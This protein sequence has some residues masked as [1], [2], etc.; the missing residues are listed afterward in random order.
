MVTYG[1]TL[2]GG[3]PIGVLCGKA[4]LMKRFDLNRPTDICFARG[5]FN[6]HPY[7]MGTMHEFLRNLNLKKIKDI[8]KNLD[9]KWNQRATYLNQRFLEERLPLRVSNFSSIWTVEYTKPSRYNWMYQYYLRA[10][11]I[12]L[13]WVG[14]GRMIFSLN[15]TDDDFQEV[16]SRM[17]AAG[18]KMKKDHWWWARCTAT[19][20]S[21]KREILKELISNFLRTKL[22]LGRN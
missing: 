22:N 2:A 16:A 8:Y 17:L 6:S 5:T 10:E 14:T 12:S 18:R 19:N 15:Y 20:K 13:G 11:T 3:L 1:K 9:E 21:L 4:H 7:V